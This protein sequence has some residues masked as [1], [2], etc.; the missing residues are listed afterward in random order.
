MNRSWRPWFLIL[1]LC[2]AFG[3][4]WV[5]RRSHVEALKAELGRAKLIQ[6]G[7][8]QARATDTP[9][10][11]RAPASVTTTQLD[12]HADAAAVA[13]LRA[14]LD[15]IKVRALKRSAAQPKVNNE[16]LTVPL[17]LSTDMVPSDQWKNAGRA[18]P[19][20]TFETALWAAAAGD[21]DS[22]A[23][24]LSI[25]PVVRIEAVKLMQM[26]PYSLRQ[27]YNTPEQVIALLATRDVPVSGAAQILDDKATGPAGTRVVAVLRDAENRRRQTH[28]LLRQDGAE[29]RLIVPASAVERYTA[30]VRGPAAA[31]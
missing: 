18:T 15:A 27:D 21:V 29:W 10:G 23:G 24:L 22:L 14:E 2:V 28:L 9:P 17:S 26:L 13:R 31:R 8:M 25:D 3:G 4:V 11:P 12:E 5:W 6:N 30:M 1:A 20:A 19:A 16:A 7:R